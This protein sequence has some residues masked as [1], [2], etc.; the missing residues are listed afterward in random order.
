MEELAKRVAHHEQR[1]GRLEAAFDALQANIEGQRVLLNHIVEQ[2]VRTV[3]RIENL[4]DR[5]SD[6]GRRTRD[7]LAEHERHLLKMLADHEHREEERQA[8]NLR[9]RHERK[10]L[11]HRARI[12]NVLTFAAIMA[13]LATVLLEPLRTSN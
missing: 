12:A 9:Y 11:E 1:I 5:V 8:Q 7:L 6:A 4:V 13:T 3:Q 10:R 2:E